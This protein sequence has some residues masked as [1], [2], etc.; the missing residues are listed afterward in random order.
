MINVS[1]TPVVL[2]SFEVIPSGS[3]RAGKVKLYSFMNGSTA[4]L[5]SLSILTA[6]MMKSLSLNL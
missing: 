2:Y 4:F 5:P 1:G 3:R 6:N